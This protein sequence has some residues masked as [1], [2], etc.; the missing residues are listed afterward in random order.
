M[1]REAAYQESVGLC[2]AES[3]EIFAV[4]QRYGGMEKG[5]S[6]TEIVNIPAWLRK[7][8]D[9]ILGALGKERRRRKALQPKPPKESN[10]IRNY[11]RR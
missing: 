2:R 7:D 11:R 1:Q 10:A 9:T 8:F 6:L 4:W 5:L 3:L